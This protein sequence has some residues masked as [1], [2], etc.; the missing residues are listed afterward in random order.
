MKLSS[1]RFVPRIAV[2][3]TLCRSLSAT[4]TRAASAS[5]SRSAFP[6][7]AAVRASPDR[8]GFSSSFSTR[9]SRAT[10]RSAISRLFIR[11][12]CV[13]RNSGLYPSTSGPADEMS[14]TLARSRSTFSTT[15]ARYVGR[16]SR[17]A[18][19]AATSAA[20][21]QRPTS[22]LLFHTTCQYSDRCTSRG[23]SSS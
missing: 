4:A 20:P 22:R 6:P 16:D 10:V 19:A 21:T 12:V 9:F 7:F 11:R 1:T 8:F 17:L 23:A 3:A 14:S 15:V 18:R 2:V 13:G 5:R